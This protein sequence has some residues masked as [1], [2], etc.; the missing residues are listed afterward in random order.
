MAIFGTIERPKKS[1]RTLRFRF[2][3]NLFLN[4][5]VYVPLSQQHNGYAQYDNKRKIFIIWKNAIN[6]EQ[7][8][9]KS[10]KQVEINE[11]ERSNAHVI[12]I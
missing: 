1:L 12:H 8:R 10:I 3:L 4:I 5:Y 6:D 11:K 7:I 9:K 2:R